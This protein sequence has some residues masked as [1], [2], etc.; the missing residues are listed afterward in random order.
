MDEFAL[1]REVVTSLGDRA[2]GPWVA[3]G[4]G[5][6]A[7]VIE[8]SQGHQAVASIDA[9]VGGVH[10]PMQAKPWHIGYRALMVSL[11]D[12][13]AMAA[14]PRYVLVA[15]NLPAA[16]P[17]W[18]ADLAA[19]MAAAARLCDTYICGGNFAKGALSITVS[20]HGEVP[21]GQAVTR[22]GACA[23]DK[24]Y[25]SGVLGGAAACVRE[26]TFDDGG[27]LSDCQARYFK[28]R[29][30]VDLADVLRQSAHAAIDVSDGLL[31]DLGH[32]CEASKLQA[33]LHSAQIPLCAGATLEDAL[34]G[35]DDYEI[36]AA[37][38]RTLPGMTCIGEL[39]AGTGVLLD[40]QTIAPRGFNHFET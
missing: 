32:L 34:V 11:S 24:L 10:F 15:V 33:N 14:T 28:P 38:D 40:G 13:A 9:L 12:L 21:T 1:I 4:P 23:G 16:D 35:G 20:V 26:Q 31:A 37:A 29:A 7:A 2:A 36:L 25:V 19:G 6:D 22:S 5:D 3:L 8:Q 17:A 27:A 30:R 39:S 18:V